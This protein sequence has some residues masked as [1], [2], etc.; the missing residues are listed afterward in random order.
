MGSNRENCQLSIIYVSNTVSAMSDSDSWDDEPTVSPADD[1]AMAAL[2][3]ERAA[4]LR[5]RTANGDWCNCQK[6][7]SVSFAKSHND[8]T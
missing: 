1:T 7:F 3:E 8:V 5:D 6:R 4:V 2:T